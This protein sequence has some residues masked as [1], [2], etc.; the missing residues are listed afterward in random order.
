MDS[1]RQSLFQCLEDTNFMGHG[2]DGERLELVRENLAT[3]T[4]KEDARWLAA[5][6]PVEAQDT[7][8]PEEN[9]NGWAEVVKR[10]PRVTTWW[11]GHSSFAS[12]SQHSAWAW[13]AR[14]N[15][16]GDGMDVL[17]GWFDLIVPAFETHRQEFWGA[18]VGRWPRDALGVA[19]GM[20][21]GASLVP[22]VK[23]ACAAGYRPETGVA[24]P[25]THA[26]LE[27]PMA[28]Q[29]LPVLL[30]HGGG[31]VLNDRKQGVL[32]YALSFGRPESWLALLR[33]QTSLVDGLDSEGQ[34][35]YSQVLEALDAEE[36]LGFEFPEASMVRAWRRAQH[37]GDVFDLM[38]AAQSRARL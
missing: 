21:P 7:R 23:A 17:K 27:H 31:S 24:C 9:F 16:S 38:E 8:V 12:W 37:L 4:E 11:E 1:A 20:V 33:L 19:L 26:V 36:E 13:A 34:P 30:Q 6:I 10:F 22:L 28:E 15:H 3:C 32:E 18:P 14:C 35:L 25:L 2:S 29:V 5:L